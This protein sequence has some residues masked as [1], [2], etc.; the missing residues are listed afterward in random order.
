V[1]EFWAEWGLLAYAGAAAWAFFEGETFVL[2]AAAAGAATGLI[3]PVL[4]TACVWIGSFAGDQLWFSLGRRYGATAVRRFRGAERRLDQAL[5]FLDR[6]GVAFVLTFRFA[7]GVR[8]VASAACGVAGMNWGRFAA[9]NFIAAGIWAC[10]FVVCGWY[11]GEWLGEGA[12][13]W[14]LGGIGLAFI[15][16]L[17]LKLRRRPAAAIGTTPAL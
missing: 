1:A 13:G 5:Q 14:L 10:S 12:L 15:A 4:L 17:L 16:A 11:L 9:L 8:N 3:D 6:F 7:Y 2:L